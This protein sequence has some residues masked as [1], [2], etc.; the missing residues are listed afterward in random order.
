MKEIMEN[1]FWMVF[2]VAVVGGISTI[3]CYGCH[4]VETT[5]RQKIS[6]EQATIRS[7]IASGLVLKPATVLPERWEKP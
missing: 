1:V 2:V 6:E 4:Q 5:S 7:N 3:L